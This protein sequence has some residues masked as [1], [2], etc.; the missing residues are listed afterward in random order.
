MADTLVEIAETRGASF[1][2]GNLAEQIVQHAAATGGALTLGDLAGH[3]PKWVQPI[4]KSFQEQTVHELPPNT[5][6]IAALIMLGILRNT[7]FLDFPVDSAESLHL[8]IEAMKL[9]F[10]DVSR[11]VADPTWMQI[12]PHDLIDSEYL[13][14]RSKSIDM[15]QAHFPDTGFPQGKGTVY[16]TT[17]DASGMMV[18]F[19]QSNYMGF[20]SGIVV[21]GT[22]IGLQNRGC[23][24]TLEAGHPNQVRGKKR[25]FHTI[26]PGFVTTHGRPI[27][28]FGVMGGHMQPQ[29]HAQIVTRICGY[30]QNPQAA[31]DAPRWRLF[32]DYRVGVEA[33]FSTDV[34]NALEAKGHTIVTDCP[35]SLFG[36][37]QL[38]YRL[39][40]GGYV[41]AS[42]PRKDG[43]AVGF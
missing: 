9:A 32:E 14:Q 24:F 11:H 35:E 2:T 13:Q 29:G 17:A 16:L 25:P 19:I 22:G 6:G 12:E 31:C 42:D 27:M 3:R 8:Q 38:I 36:G 34:L 15:Q 10:A 28:S 40:D 18:S 7:D 33:G 5:Q 37:A 26:I 30:G 43:L 21:P 4:S 23:G 39:E 20:G 1:Y 41:S